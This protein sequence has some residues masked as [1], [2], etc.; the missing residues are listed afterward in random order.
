MLLH[1]PVEPEE[2]GVEKAKARA[3][4]RARGRREAKSLMINNK[5]IGEMLKMTR[6]KSLMKKKMWK[7]KLNTRR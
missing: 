5:V 4:G 6:N 3:K 7:G 2:Q 1:D